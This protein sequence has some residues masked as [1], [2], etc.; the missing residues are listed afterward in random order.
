MTK[1]TLPKKLAWVIFTLLLFTDAFLDVIRGAEGNP[2]WKPVVEV[3]GIKSVPLLVP[4]ALIF[5]Y[6]VVKA[7]SWFVKKV[8]KFP[9]AEDVILSTLVVVYG[10]FVLWVI[11]VD[12]FG[13]RLIH[14]H[15]QMTPVLVVIALA[16]ALGAEYVIKHRK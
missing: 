16:Y 13:F 4:L 2:L 15:Y 10:V 9:E 11:A 6:L 14:N 3:I 1:V 5:F 7:V 12:F 8:D